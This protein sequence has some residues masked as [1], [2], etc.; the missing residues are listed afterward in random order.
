MTTMMK[1]C[2]WVVLALGL[3]GLGPRAHAQSGPDPRQIEQALA[4]YADE[5]SVDALVEAAV[6]HGGA[7]P[8]RANDAMDR[9]RATGWLPTMRLGIRRGQAVDLRTQLT[10]D[11]ERLNFATDDALTLDGS[12]VFRLDRIAFASEEVGLLREHRFLAQRR[13]ELVRVVITLYFERR[14]LQLERD[15]SGAHDPARAV[16]LLECE[17]LIDALTGGALGRALRPGSR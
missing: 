4:R 9:A 12:L 7:D 15:L 1:R 8:G 3:L 17:A 14:R 16:R 11:V 13:L 10:G 2:G 6:R 5:P